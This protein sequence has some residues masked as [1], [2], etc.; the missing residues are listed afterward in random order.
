MP[1][2]QHRMIACDICGKKKRSS[3][4]K[5]HLAVH[6]RQEKDGEVF[7]RALNDPFILWK[8][9]LCL[10]TMSY[11]KKNTHH[12][13]CFEIYRHQHLE[14]VRKGII[15]PDDKENMTPD[16]TPGSTAG[17]T[18]EPSSDSEDSEIT[19][20]QLPAITTFKSRDSNSSSSLS[21]LPPP[22]PET[23]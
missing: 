20:T 4:M 2:G 10:F 21:S 18:A 5:R 9:P 17:K 14:L 8:C 7:R 22:V 3:N 12:L 23:E 19:V 13:Q 6:K 1:K 11:R 16:I 15:P